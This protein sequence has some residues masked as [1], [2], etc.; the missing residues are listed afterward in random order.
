MDTAPQN[1]Q[2]KSNQSF[3]YLEDPAQILL[4]ADRSALM[5]VYR[6]VIGRSWT[7]CARCMGRRLRP[8]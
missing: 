6:A 3:S 7:T 8:L 5:M 2:V 4:G 1:T